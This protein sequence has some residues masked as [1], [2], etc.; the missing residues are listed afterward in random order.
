MKKQFQNL[1][2]ADDFNMQKNLCENIE[3]VF[4]PPGT[5][6]TT[7]AKIIANST[8]SNFVKVNAALAG[9]KDLREI[10]KSAEDQKNFY[11]KRTILF[12]IAE[13]CLRFKTRIKSP[14]QKEKGGGGIRNHERF[15]FCERTV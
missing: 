15:I 1:D 6:K 14:T 3:F 11:G 9:I 5:G 8:K 7:L 10:V 13:F 4:G 12:I 2:K